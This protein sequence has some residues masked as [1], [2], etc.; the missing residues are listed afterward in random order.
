[1][2]FRLPLHKDLFQALSQALRV[3]LALFKIMIPVIVGVKILQELDLIRYIALPLSPLMKM[4]GLPPEMGLVWATGMINNLYGAIIVLLS[5]WDQVPLSAAQS[6]VLCTLMLVAHTLPIELKI[7]QRAGVRLLFQ[8]FSRLTFA[9]LL[10]WILH[11]I[12]S[13]F[14]LLQEPARILFQPGSSAMPQNQ[15]LL[16]WGIGEIRKLLSI[17]LIIVSLF[18]LM[19]LL[20]RFGIIDFIS[21]ILSPVLR[22]MGIGPRATTVT[23]IG[24][25][26]GIVYGGGLIIHEART[27]TIPRKDIFYSLSLMGLCHALIEDTMLMMVIGGDVSGILFARLFFSV[28]I[29]GLLVRITSR[30]PSTFCRN[31]L[32]G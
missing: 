29:V 23:V 25:T 24:L 4:V 17:L 22:I 20:N 5:L 21:R 1:M 12:Y 32:W 31:W 13:H 8:A 26:M 30:L 3:G 28:L 14:N 2:T 6:T 9:I 27:G 16:V 7:A 15:T 11:S 19:R 18:L 10:G